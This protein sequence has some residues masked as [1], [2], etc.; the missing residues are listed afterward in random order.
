MALIHSGLFLFSESNPIATCYIHLDLCRRLFQ[1]LALNQL[2]GLRI[3]TFWPSHSGRFSAVLCFKDELF[4][5]H[6]WDKFMVQFG[7]SNS[8]ISSIYNIHL[9]HR[10]TITPLPPPF[11]LR[12]QLRKFRRPRE[13]QGCHCGGHEE[14]QGRTRTE[15]RKNC[16]QTRFFRDRNMWIKRDPAGSSKLC[17]SK[18]LFL[19][20]F[21]AAVFCYWDD[22]TW[23]SRIAPWFG[24]GCPA[25]TNDGQPLLIQTGHGQSPWTACNIVNPWYMHQSVFGTCIWFIDV[26]WCSMNLF[27]A[28][29]KLEAIIF[30]SHKA[31]AVL[32]TMGVCYM[33]IVKH[34]H[35]K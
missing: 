27:V 19:L 31:S 17:F 30:Y 22:R 34:E 9:A 15:L 28:I 33:A 23:V 13:G 25:P 1:S 18:L 4:F 2:M 10:S 7:T 11:S 29:S 6:T 3:P 14:I 16:Q 5:H 26:H 8:L 21:M 12:C 35:P 24:T 32:P 20:Y